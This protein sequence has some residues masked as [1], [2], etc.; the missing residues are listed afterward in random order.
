MTDFMTPPPEEEKSYTSDQPGL[1]E[2]AIEI[3]SNEPE[4]SEVKLE[5]LR[6]DVYPGGPWDAGEG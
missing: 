4:I 2:A 5:D 1:R 6:D 3:G